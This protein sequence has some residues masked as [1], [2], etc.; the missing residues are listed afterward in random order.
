MQGERRSLFLVSIPGINEWAADIEKTDSMGKDGASSASTSI[1]V[2][3]GVK[4]HLVESDAMEN[5]NVL[6][7]IDLKDTIQMD[8]APTS[9]LSAEYLLNSPLPDRPGKACIAKVGVD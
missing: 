3:L 9:G 6:K 4:R 1:K 2:S 7:K 5:E 8:V